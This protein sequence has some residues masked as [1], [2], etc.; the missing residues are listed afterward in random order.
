MRD[1]GLDRTLVPHDWISGYPAPKNCDVGVQ[2]NPEL[3]DQ[4]PTFLWVLLAEESFAQLS[5]LIFHTE[6]E[7]AVSGAEV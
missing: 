4:T 1:H 2:L 3:R 5:G 7:S 6:H